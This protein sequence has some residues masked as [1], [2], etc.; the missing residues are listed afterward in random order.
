MATSD[1]HAGRGAQAADVIEQAATVVAELLR[2]RRARRVPLS[3]LS[4]TAVDRV[5]D[6]TLRRAVTAALAA[7]LRQAV[8]E[9]W[10]RGWQPADVDR[11]ARRTLDAPTGDL[12]AEGMRAELAT[13]PR[14]QVDPGWWQQ[15]EEVG[16]TTTSGARRRRADDPEDPASAW[17][18]SCRATV[19][20][21][22]FVEQLPA[23]AV[24]GTL[25]GERQ[26]HGRGT[27][28]VDD[29]L[30]TRVRRLL[31]QAEG[32]PY[33]AEAETFT[34]AAQSLMARHRIDRAMLDASDPDRP[35]RGPDAV[36][37]TVDRPYEGP[38]MQLL[39]QIC[40]AN[41]CR[42]VWSQFAGFATVVG[43]EA[44]RRAVELLFTSLLVQATSAMQRE[45]QQQGDAARSRGFRSSF[46]LGFATR[47]GQRLEQTSSAE[48]S[49]AS[50]RLSAGA[51]AEGA[52]TTA[53]P[54]RADPLALVLSRRKV[55]VQA[56]LREIF[57][58]LQTGRARQISDY[59]GYLQGRAAADRATL[60]VGGRLTGRAS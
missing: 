13:Y 39:H 47:I 59:G 21:T 35:G 60:G 49:A 22:V 50:A 30:L 58:Q 11:Y 42:A 55:D 37:L 12:L 43:F 34:A 19:E 9:V 38:K 54:V 14:G 31:A 4:R 52:E 3:V 7:A 5:D 8:S 51:S 23:L 20:A 45:G 33:E 46:L 57:P 16:G 40:T 56:R 1:D 15:L 24:I 53:E 18:D 29:K 2:H 28:P 27:P 6:P 17:Q 48:E 44:D 41:R 10:P 32:T 36:R 26:R 25:P